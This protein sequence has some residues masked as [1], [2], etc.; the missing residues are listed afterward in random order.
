MTEPV[1]GNSPRQES[2]H[3]TS[4]PHPF[5]LRE[6]LRYIGNFSDQ[7]TT[8]NLHTVVELELPAWH[9]S[10]INFQGEWNHALSLFG[11]TTQ[12]LTGPQ[13]LQQHFTGI[14]SSAGDSITEGTAIHTPQS[15]DEV[16]LATTLGWKPID[17]LSLGLR[18]TL[19][20]VSRTEDVATT[21]R[22][23]S[24]SRY[25]EQHVG[26]NG[27]IPGDIYC[28]NG[29]G[30]IPSPET[31][32]P[33][34]A[35]VMGPFQQTG[36]STFNVA[37]RLGGLVSYTRGILQAGA[38]FYLSVGSRKIDMGT[39]A[40]WDPTIRP[41]LRLT[42]PLSHSIQ[43]SGQIRTILHMGPPSFDVIG[44]FGTAF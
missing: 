32:T 17:H 44:A 42:V 30:N 24:G 11:T 40:S 1:S 28:T 26:S 12:N 20:F 3:E 36:L 25:Q 8:L 41:Y 33:R 10:S 6:G 13:V 14:R 15:F 18:A 4:P 21:V 31:A 38:D 35:N 34:A 19:V 7:P 27:C 16:V 9:H 22:G 37:A 43:F 2:G 23:V 5:R 29:N 39:E